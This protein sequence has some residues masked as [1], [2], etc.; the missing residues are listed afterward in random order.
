[1]DD[2]TFRN[3]GPKGYGYAVPGATIAGPCGDC[4]RLRGGRRNRKSLKGDEIA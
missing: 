4:R 1:M 2:H 3:V